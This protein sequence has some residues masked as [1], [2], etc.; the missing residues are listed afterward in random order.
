MTWAPLVLPT[1]LLLAGVITD[2]R[3]RKVYN[4]M[5]V[6]GL[7]LAIIQVLY[8]FGLS[9]LGPALMAGGLALLLTLPLVL[10][11]VLGAGDM[12]LLTVFGIATSY[13]AVIS[14][15]LYSFVWAAIFGL[16][17][18]ILSGQI[19]SVGKNMLAI[20]KGQ[21]PQAVTLHKIPFTVAIAVAWGTYVL[22]LRGGL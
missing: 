15:T 10:V 17:H 12:K 5:I 14:V 6:A 18:A 9:A 19:V 20:S 3:A 11:G 4:W 21:K 8:V 1:L 16:I 2:L 7:A 13:S 22:S